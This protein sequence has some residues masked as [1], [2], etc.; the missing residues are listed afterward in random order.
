MKE[1][2]LILS[3]AEERIAT[4]QRISVDGSEGTITL[5]GQRNALSYIP[6]WGA[7]DPL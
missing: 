6:E 3:C 1:D 7:D 4:G 5:E 2:P